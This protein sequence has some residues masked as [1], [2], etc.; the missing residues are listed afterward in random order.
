M[1]KTMQINGMMCNHCKMTVEKALKAVPGVE[2]AEV[3]LAAKC[4]KITLNADVADDVLMDA[5]AKKGFTPVEMGEV[6][7]KQKRGRIRWRRLFGST[8]GCISGRFAAGNSTM[9]RARRGRTVTS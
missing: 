7:E 2:N 9:C 8:R 5:V 1:E 6:S 4:A 3:D